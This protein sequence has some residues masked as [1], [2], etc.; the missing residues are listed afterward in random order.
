MQ[1]K[2]LKGCS[3]KELK[4]LGYSVDDLAALLAWDGGDPKT[5]ADL[6]AI[7]RR[8]QLNNVDHRGSQLPWPRDYNAAYAAFNMFHRVTGL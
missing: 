6:L 8:A 3:M 4:I 7:V 5:P 2:K 1:K